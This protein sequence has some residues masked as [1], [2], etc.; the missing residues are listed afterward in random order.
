M[1]IC[2]GIPRRGS[3]LHVGTAIIA[4]LPGS[5]KVCHTAH[6]DYFP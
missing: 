6:P 2:A 1:Q 3:A 4:M 5:V